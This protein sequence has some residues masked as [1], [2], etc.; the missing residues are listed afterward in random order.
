MNIRTRLLAIFFLMGAVILAYA[1]AVSSL[2][3]RQVQL[4]DETLLKNSQAHALANSLMIQLQ[5]TRRYEKE[6]FIYVGHTAKKAKYIGEWTES[7]NKVDVMIKAMIDDADGLFDDNDAIEFIE[8]QKAIAFYRSEFEKIIERYAGLNEVGEL[9][10]VA[11]TQHT[12]DANTQIADGKNRLKLV[13]SG[14]DTLE[15]KKDTELVATRAS[16]QDSA[17]MIAYL[18][19]GAGLLVLVT[20]LIGVMTLDRS[21]MGKFRKIIDQTRSMRDGDMGVHFQKTGINELDEL[22]ASLEIIKTKLLRRS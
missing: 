5:K 8:W 7:M 21:F 6:Y 9:A 22:S 17:D 12:V 20:M 16:V 10:A 13:F 15:A 3:N 19:Y 11:S 18:T 2:S 14:L 1:L 4:V